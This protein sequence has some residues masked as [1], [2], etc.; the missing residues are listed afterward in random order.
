[1]GALDA[2][3]IWIY[4]EFE[5]AAPVSDMLNR[6]ANSV[7]DAIEPLAFSTPW[8]NLQLETGVATT[9]GRPPQY[10]RIANIVYF[11]GSCNGISDSGTARVVGYLPEGFRPTYAIQEL[12]FLATGT[13]T[14]ARAYVTNNG[15][16]T[17]TSGT[18]LFLAG[19]FAI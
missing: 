4:D 8:Q 12:G 19:S 1:M 9:N 3:G 16:L 6:L 14:S 15:V 2:N 10:R 11:R 18:A 17:I 13:T 5:D 7:S